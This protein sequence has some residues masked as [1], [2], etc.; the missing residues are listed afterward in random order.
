MQTGDGTIQ[1]KQVVDHVLDIGSYTF[2]H[3]Q[4]SNCGGSPP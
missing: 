1:V 3:I 4:M 2:Q